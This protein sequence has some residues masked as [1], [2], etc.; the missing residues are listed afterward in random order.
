[1]SADWKSYNSTVGKMDKTE[2][3]AATV[4]ISEGF[5]DVLYLTNQ[6]RMPPE[7]KHLLKQKMLSCAM[8]PLDRFPNILH[9]LNLIGTV[10]IDTAG[11]EVSQQS[12]LARIIESLEMGDVGAIL[13]ND[14]VKM[15]VKSFCLAGPQVKS[16]ALTTTMESVATDKLWAQISINLAYRRKSSPLAGRPDSASYDPA[17]TNGDGLAEQLG[18]IETLVD[19]LAEELRMAGLVQRDFLPT[20]LPDTDQLKW[21]VLF[22]PAAWVSGDI[23]DVTRIDEQH[24][25]FYIADA[26][27]HGM[28]AALLTIF[29]KQALVMRETVG[30]SYRI[31]SPAE[32]MKA[33]NDRVAAQ[34]LSGYQF[35]TCCYCILNIKTL[36]LTYARAGHPY[37]ILLR[38]GQPPKQLET[39]G[40]LLGIFEQSEYVQQTIQLQHGD[41]LLLYSDGAEPFIGS[42][43][44][45]TGFNFSDE[46]C[47]IRDLPVGEMADR[48]NM[49]VASKKVAP[50]EVDDVTVLGLQIL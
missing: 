9:R 20:Q 41:R 22:L 4:D 11:L 36:E 13:L 29:L 5:I 42:F 50:S 21:G 39:G 2:Q 14:R 10:I 7:V 17:Q 49:L 37:P 25:G 12:K 23:Y 6:G 44:D 24:I 28:P 18:M 47:E 30:H 32:V 48:L 1:M 43:D 19:N 46:F 15:P 33:L 40:A 8:L 3:I 38:P 16:F 45:L 34:K 35:A 27:G 26:V 31:F